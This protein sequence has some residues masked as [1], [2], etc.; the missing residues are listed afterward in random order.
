LRSQFSVVV[1]KNLIN[2]LLAPAFL[3]VESIEDISTLN[4]LVE[5]TLIKGTRLF[6]VLELDLHNFVILI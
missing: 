1:G 5:G 3:L 4:H 2:Y 6:W